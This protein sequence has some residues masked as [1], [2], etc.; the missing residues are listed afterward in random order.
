MLLVFLSATI[1]LISVIRVLFC[2]ISLTNTEY[3]MIDPIL[4]LSVS[5]AE[6]RRAYAFFLGSG[7][8]KAASIPTGGEI[9]WDTV[10]KL[11]QMEVESVPEDDRQL[12][13]W[14]Q[15]SKYRD[16]TYSKILGELCR[17]EAGRRDFLEKYFIG[18]SPTKAHEQLAVLVAQGLVKIIVTTNFDQ[19][20]ERILEDE[21]VSFDVV[22]SA[23]DFEQVIPR[24]HSNCRILKIHGDYKRL[25]IRNTEQ[26]L[27][28]LEPGIAEE[29]Q[30]VLNTYGLV[31]I[32]YSGS[33]KAVLQHLQK[34]RSRYG[35]YWVK[36]PD[37][38]VN[39][40]VK[41]IL[42][43]Q[44]GRIIVRESADIFFD[45]LCRKIQLFHAHPTG[46]T[47]EFLANQT[48]QLLRGND[49]IGIAELLKK[50][51]N[52][53][54]QDWEDVYSQWAHQQNKVEEAYEKL[55][56]TA[57]RFEA[58]GLVCIEYQAEEMYQRLLE[59]F[60]ELVRLE[61]HRGGLTTLL[62]IHCAVAYRLFYT[63]GTQ[64]IAHEN[65][66]FL[67][68]MFSYQF[69]YKGD[70][71]RLVNRGGVFHPPIHGNHLNDSFDYVKEKLAAQ[72]YLQESF[73]KFAR[74]SFSYLCQFD[75]ICSKGKRRRPVSV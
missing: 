75:L 67:R 4:P 27:A 19:L 12:K 42:R 52:A 21:G 11:Y 6:G 73:P 39:E 24:E 22:A 33:D 44:D 2:N 64:C 18:K 70:Y 56:S 59:I 5:I 71:Q 13:A 17:P 28:E 9:F 62:S 49:I 26:E 68:Q 15:E 8:S 72:S 74:D 54:R 50:Q 23:A 36:R 65:L 47:P 31:F 46:D 25:N 55:E 69:P 38:S 45:E 7:I 66:D 10:R 14:F 53:F 41:E 1:G 57:E 20:M 40:A 3:S 16:F 58:I 51:L 63:W 30:D 37:G 32:G 60:G 35:I 43:N 34:R 48:I 29:F 61:E